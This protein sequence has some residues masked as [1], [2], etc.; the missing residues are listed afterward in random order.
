[1]AP[2]VTLSLRILRLQKEKG[3]LMNKI[4]QDVWPSTLQITKTTVISCS[5]LAACIM[6]DTKHGSQTKTVGL[7]RNHLFRQR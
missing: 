1:M 4:R 3:S 5:L 6:Q 7:W 2:T